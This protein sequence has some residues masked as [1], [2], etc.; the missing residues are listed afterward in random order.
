[1][2]KEKSQRLFNNINGELDGD[3]DD[4]LSDTN[5][6]V[7]PAWIP[8]ND[9]NDTPKNLNSSSSRRIGHS[10]KLTKKQYL[11]SDHS[12]STS[13]SLINNNNNHLDESTTLFKVKIILNYYSFIFYLL[14]IY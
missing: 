8:N 1:M 5:S 13:S 12:A 6:D 9:N 4:E 10:K 7:D 3:E 14:F 11:N 2:A